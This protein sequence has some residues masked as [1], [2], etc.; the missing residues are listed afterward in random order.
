MDEESRKIQKM[1]LSSL[2]V[3]LPKDWAT[4]LG[5]EPGSSVELSREEDGSIKVSVPDNKLRQVPGC[6]IRLE[7]C[8][9]PGVLERVVIGNYLLGRDSIEVKSKSAFPEWAMEEVYD[10]VDRLTG[11]AIAGEP[12]SLGGELRGTHQVPREGPA[13]EASV[14]DPEDGRYLLPG[15][16]QTHPRGSRKPRPTGRGGGQAILVGHASADGRGNQ[17]ACGGPDRRDRSEAHR[18]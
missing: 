13:A 9:E 7:G 5:L 15:D 11:V 1:G 8:G 4:A 3:S 12:L 17:Q 2:G 14:P 18:W 16:R 6:T 10:A